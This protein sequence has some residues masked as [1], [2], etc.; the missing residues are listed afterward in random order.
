MQFARSKPEPFIIVLLVLAVAAGAAFIL[1]PHIDSSYN[2][3]IPSGS[4]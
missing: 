3:I 1:G 2:N 4:E